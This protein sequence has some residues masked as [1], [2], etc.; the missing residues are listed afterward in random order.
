M[1]LCFR[2]LR[3]KLAENSGWIGKSE[4]KDDENNKGNQKDASKTDLESVEEGNRM[5]MF[6]TILKSVKMK[7]PDSITVV[8]DEDGSYLHPVVTHTASYNKEIRVWRT[9]ASK[10]AFQGKVGRTPLVEEVRS[11]HRQ[12][13]LIPFRGTN[14]YALRCRCFT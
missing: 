5:S 8:H 6:Q 11:S 10:C 14:L 1:R 13:V 3:R 9:D 2:N 7:L 4:E 12:Q